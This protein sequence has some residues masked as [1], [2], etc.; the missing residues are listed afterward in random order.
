MLLARADPQAEPPMSA[1]N[2]HR[3]PAER[4]A[5]RAPPATFSR[6]GLLASSFPA[7]ATQ[8]K[9]RGKRKNARLQGKAISAAERA[10]PAKKSAA[11]QLHC[12][13]ATETTMTNAMM[14]R[15]MRFEQEQR[16]EAVRGVCCRGRARAAAHWWRAALSLGSP[17]SARWQNAAEA[18]K[19][20][21]DKRESK[22]C[23]RVMRLSWIRTRLADLMDD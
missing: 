21:P 4:A 9:G 6:G 20:S 15:R 10:D 7:A 14:P 8:G 19:I 16:T 3:R 5:R 13:C 12:S 2:G 23:G 22:A 17:R 11:W 18:A 1:Q